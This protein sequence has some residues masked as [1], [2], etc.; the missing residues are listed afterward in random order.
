NLSATSLY[1]GQNGG[2]GGITRTG[3]GKLTISSAMY[4]NGGNFSFAPA[5]ATSRLYLSN[6]AAATTKATG[7]VTGDV[8]VGAGS[9]LTLGAYLYL[10]NSLT[11]SGTLNPNGNAIAATSITMNATSLGNRG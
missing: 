2:T 11:V 4:Q 1:L 5:D 6:N 3:G 10:S 7:N 9:T 8:A